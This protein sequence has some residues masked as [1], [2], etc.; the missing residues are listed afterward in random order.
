[1]AA[2]RSKAR[3][4]GVCTP[5]HRLAACCDS[6]RQG[7]SRAQ[8]LLVAKLAG[9]AAIVA[10]LGADEGLQRHDELTRR[11]KREN[12]GE[13]ASAAYRE[14]LR[15]RIRRRHS[16]GEKRERGGEDELTSAARTTTAAAGRGGETRCAAS[17]RRRRRSGRR[18]GEARLRRRIGEIA[19]TR[20][21]KTGRG[22]RAG[23]FWSC[24]GREKC[25]EPFWGRETV[26]TAPDARASGCVRAT[27]AGACGLG[28]HLGA[29]WPVG[30]A[31][32]GGGAWAACLQLARARGVGWRRCEL[33]RAAAG[34]LGWELAAR[35]D[36]RKSAG[37][38]G[39][40]GQELGRALWTERGR[41]RGEGGRGWAGRNGPGREAGLKSV[42]SFPFLFP[43]SFLFISV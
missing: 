37:A 9:G 23:R 36:P 31:Q 32:A 30:Q 28:W 4:R 27:H 20:A 7:N 25:A 22:A 35:A 15:A 6:R 5:G 13:L 21:R 2:R 1:V 16:A 11:G 18:F 17:T 26:F 39:R 19:A 24:R 14:A 43:F 40:K 34:A 29:S 38:G 33:G 8:G 41:K 12:G 42:F 3:A 10:A